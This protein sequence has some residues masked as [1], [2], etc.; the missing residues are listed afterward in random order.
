MNT[1]NVLRMA[2]ISIFLWIADT[3]SL[4][5]RNI[6]FQGRERDKTR[7]GKKQRKTII[8]GPICMTTNKKENACQFIYRQAF[9]LL[10][11]FD[12]ITDCFL[13]IP[14]G[15]LAGSPATHT[16]FLMWTV[17]RFDHPERT[18]ELPQQIAFPFECDMSSTHAL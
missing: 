1:K 11:S 17:M 6:C 3:G 9:N 16:A 8:P 18:E 5:A 10:Y 13:H 14:K 2:A 4:D 15:L 12:C 7:K